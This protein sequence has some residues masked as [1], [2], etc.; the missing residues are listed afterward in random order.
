MK[1]S[2]YYPAGAYLDPDAPYNQHDPDPVEFDVTCVQTLSKTVPVETCNYTEEVDEEYD[3][4]GQKYRSASYDTSDVDWGEEYTNNDYHTPLQLINL[5]K[6]YLEDM[7]NGTE[8]CIKSPA[9][10]KALI[11]ECEGW[12]DDE[13]TFVED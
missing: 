10:L 4:E 12:E 6:R 3:E 13:T 2:D 8:T 5:F 11:N 9:F 1:E 7:V